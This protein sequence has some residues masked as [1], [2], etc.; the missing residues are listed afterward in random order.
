[1]KNITIDGIEYAPIIKSS[2]NIVLVRTYSAGVHMGELIS[3]N[4]NEIVLKNARRIWRWYG[5]A[6]LSQL[7]MEGTTLPNDC[8]FPCKVNEI[9]LWAIEIIPMTPQAI[10]SLDNVP[11]WQ[12][13]KNV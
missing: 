1:M 2:D 5:A 10:K 7:G 12:A 9:T 3:K 13:E 6:T 11:I 4:N 8:K